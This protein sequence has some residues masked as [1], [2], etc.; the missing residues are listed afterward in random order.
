MTKGS[1]LPMSRWSCSLVLG[2]P[3]LTAC[4]AFGGSVT[5]V[6][7]GRAHEGHYIPPESYA[8]YARGAQLEALGQY[9]EAAHAYETAIEF[10][11]DSVGI[12]TRLGSVRCAS[13]APAAD[14]AFER[15][16]RLDPNFAALWY[17]RGRCDLGRE[18]PSQANTAAL[19]ALSLDPLH[20]PTT[21]LVVE[22]FLRS[23][24]TDAALRYLDAA[25]ALHPN[26]EALTRLK[27][28]IMHEGRAHE[29]RAPQPAAPKTDAPVDLAELDRALL[30]D[31]ADEARRL[32]LELDLPEGEVAARAVA[33]GKTDAGLE[34]ANH[35]HRADPADGTAW[36]TV[37]SSADL[38][39]NDALFDAALNGLDET[40]TLPSALGSVLLAD[41]L[42]RR[43]GAEAAR[44]WLRAAAASSPS[45]PLV[46]RQFNR[47]ERELDDTNHGDAASK[48]ESPSP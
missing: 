19:R 43:V 45:D 12:W 39:R 41:L 4:S 46:A 5:R 36:V 18:K 8:A 31:T 22:T 15:A 28:A 48:A 47:L 20:L 34:Q 40:P 1:A 13:Q 33:L 44:A 16:E 9:P 11:P 30:N 38:T 29:G 37:L 7:D 35:V 10:D 3:L 17:E 2:L 25:I 14:E 27:R 6:V 23:K 42:K 24:R 21:V 26:L 32:A